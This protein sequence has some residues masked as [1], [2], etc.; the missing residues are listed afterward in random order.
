M[1]KLSI[2]VPYRNR[3]QHLR[4]FAPHMNMFLNNK[5]VFNIN[6]IEQCNNKPFNRG[7]L[8]NIGFDLTQ[9]ESQYCCIHDVDHIPVSDF[10]DYSYREGVTKLATRVSQFGFKRRNRSELAGVVLFD[11]ETFKKV[12]GFSNEYWGWGVE[13]ND[14]GL[15]CLKKEI[16]I[17]ERDGLYMYY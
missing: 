15:R 5:I 17:E 9:S 11:N 7:L 10:S 2:I 3:E 16:S 1:K 13:D 4:K 12:N 6:I 14:L 8:A